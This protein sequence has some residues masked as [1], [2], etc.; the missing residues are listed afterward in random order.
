MDVYLDGH[1]FGR[2][3]LTVIHRQFGFTA[4][5][6]SLNRKFG[7]RPFGCPGTV[8]LDPNIQRPYESPMKKAFGRIPV[9]IS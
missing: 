5:Q 2:S 7:L 1:A 9:D 3:K 6:T 8:D 4:T